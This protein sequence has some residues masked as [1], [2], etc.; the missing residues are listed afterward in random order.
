MKNLFDFG[1]VWEE[2]NVWDVFIDLRLR[3][4]DRK[5]DYFACWDYGPPFAYGS[6]T[7]PCVHPGMDVLHYRK[8]IE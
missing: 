4:Y 5:N 2:P 6:L 7:D 8:V 1:V 3:I